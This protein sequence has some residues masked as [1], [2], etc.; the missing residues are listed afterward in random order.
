MPVNLISF[1]RFQLQ[2]LNRKEEKD[3]IKIKIKQPKNEGNINNRAKFVLL[4]V[5][6]LLFNFDFTYILFY[7]VKV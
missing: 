7:N 4:L 6:L 5:F 2:K 1:M 3:G